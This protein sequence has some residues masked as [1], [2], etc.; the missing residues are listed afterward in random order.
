MSAYG[1]GRDQEYLDR[2]DAPINDFVS[3]YNANPSPDHK[4]IFLFP[5]GMGSQLMRADGIR[6]E[7][8]TKARR[9]Q[10]RWPNF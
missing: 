8:A 1:Q 7:P 6:R 5:G 10:R 4:T 3:R 9:Q 2:L